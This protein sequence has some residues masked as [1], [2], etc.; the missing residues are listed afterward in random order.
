VSEMTC[1]QCAAS[2]TRRSPTQRYCETCSIKRDRDRKIAWTARNP[3]KSN[4][5]KTKVRNAERSAALALVGA[6]RQGEG[7]VGMGGARLEVDLEWVVRTSFPFSYALSKNAQWSSARGGG[8]VFLRKNASV[9]R[10]IVRNVIAA[11]LAR[12]SKTLVEAKVYIDIF[13]QKPDHRGDAINV[14]DSVCDAV[15]VA[16]G[17]DDRWF[18][19]RGLDWEIVKH[20]PQVFVGIGQATSEPQRVCSCCGAIKGLESFNKNRSMLLGR[21][22]ECAE[23]LAAIRAR[24]PA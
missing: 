20:D 11:A 24:R 3:R 13:V 15:K 7:S 10:G 12:A 14:L 18:V 22:R 23:C 21:S 1:G 16:V 4:P 2:V 9:H 17:V 8:H 19:L 6:E 5:A